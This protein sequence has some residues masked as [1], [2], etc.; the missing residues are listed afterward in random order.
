MPNTARYTP[1]HI[2]NKDTN[3]S[4]I[5]A[6]H[7]HPGSGNELEAA[8][9]EATA[10]PNNGPSENYPTYSK[11]TNDEKRREREKARQARQASRQYQND[12]R[13]LAAKAGG[14]NLVPETLDITIRVVRYPPEVAKRLGDTGLMPFAL[15]MLYAKEWLNDYLKGKAK[16]E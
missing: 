5:E 1:N 10:L 9:D 11:R 7:M 16:F 2:S 13:R 12:C 3:I 15:Q 6:L 4:E 8:R 14:A